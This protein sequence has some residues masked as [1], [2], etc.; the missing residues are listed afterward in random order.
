MKT[1]TVMTTFVY[2]QEMTIIYYIMTVTSQQWFK[3]LLVIK[4]RLLS[5]ILKY[6]KHV[7]LDMMR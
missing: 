6:D 7:F 5:K 3:V 2:T 4:Y 1:W